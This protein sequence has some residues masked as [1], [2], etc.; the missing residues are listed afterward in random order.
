MYLP[1]LLLHLCLCVCTYIWLQMDHPT[2]RRFINVLHR[3]QNEHDLVHEQ[4]IAGHEAPKKRAKY[5]RADRRIERIVA[6]YAQLMFIDWNTCAASLT[7]S[8]WIPEL[9]LALLY[10]LPCICG[11]IYCYMIITVIYLPYTTPL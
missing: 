4:L 11:H 2:I 1:S 5:V 10:L 9:F 3:I 8:K 7:T 6:N